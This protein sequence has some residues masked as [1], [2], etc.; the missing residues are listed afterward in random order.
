MEYNDATLANGMQMIGWDPAA[1]QVRSWSF[2]ADGGH[3]ESVWTKDG[4]SWVAKTKA[5][6]A[7]GTAVTATNIMT[8]MDDN[9]VKVASKERTVGGKAMPDAKETTLKRVVGE[10]SPASIPLTSNTTN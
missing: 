6:L 9:T 3:G 4:S 7:D 10:S 5:T 1:K 8:V 2:E